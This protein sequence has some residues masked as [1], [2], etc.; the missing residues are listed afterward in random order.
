MWL[1][2]SARSVRML[3]EMRGAQI[4]D[5]GIAKAELLELR[6]LLEN[7]HLAIGDRRRGERDTRPRARSR[8]RTW[9]PIERSHFATASSPLPFTD[10]ASTA[11]LAVRFDESSASTRDARNAGHQLLDAGGGD[12][13]VP[14]VERAELRQRREA[15]EA[16]VRDLRAIE[17]QLLETRSSA[18]GARGR[19]R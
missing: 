14:N 15:S 8:S 1:R 2:S 4:A 19:C 7:R 13:A 10:A 6:Q 12:A 11:R 16:G 17:R 18:R 3:R 9:A 5:F